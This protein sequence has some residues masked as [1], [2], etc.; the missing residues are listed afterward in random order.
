MRVRRGDPGM[1]T[2]VRHWLIVLGAVVVLAGVY[3]VAG[4]VGVPHLLRSQLL[5]FVSEHYGRTASIGTIRFNPFTFALEMRDFS[6]PD[7]DGRPLLAFGRLALDLDTAT[8]WRAAPSFSTI[9]I[10]RPFV[11]A[12]LRKDGALNLA[13]LAKPF[14]NAAAPPPPPDT[15]PARLFVQHFGVVAGNV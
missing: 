3:A 1:T 2:A 4:F 10:E 5:S 15:P 7:S 11:R 8:I 12:Q 13:D 9:E 6:F 14:D